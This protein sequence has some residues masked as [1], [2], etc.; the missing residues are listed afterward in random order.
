MIATTLLHI[1][2]G[3]WTAIAAWAGVAIAVI[4]G[5]VAY[6]QLGE[7]RQLRRGQAQPYVVASAETS[8]AGEWVVDLVI[9]NLGKTAARN[10]H[11]VVDPPAMRAA[12]AAH[13]DVWIP[14]VMPVLVPGQEWRTFLGYDD[15]PPWLGSSRSPRGE[16]RVRGLS[17]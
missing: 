8:P 9:R 1:S 7:A 14:A 12:D 10:I 13:P 4:A 17:R 11:V 5:K 6:S 15:R 3:A 16:S 2:S